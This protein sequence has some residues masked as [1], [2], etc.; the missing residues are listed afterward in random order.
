MNLEGP[1]NDNGSFLFSARR[2]YLDLIFEAAGFAFIPEYWDFHAK[3]NQRLNSSNTLSFL[4]IGAIGSVKLNNDNEENR[5]DNSRVAVPTQKQ[6]FSGLTWKHLFEKGFTTVTLGQTLTDYSTFQN[7]INLNKIL[8]N[9]SREAE[10]SLRTDVDIM[11]TSN[12]QLT[13]GNQLKWATKLKY[14]VFVAGFFRTD[15]NGI[16]QEL[17]I[18]TTFQTYKNST[19]VSY[20]QGIGQHKFTLGGRLEYINYVEEKWLFSPRISVLYQINPVS[21]ISVSGGRYFQSPSKIWLIGAPQNRQLKAIQADQ[22]VLAY[23]HTPLE[24]VKVQVEVYHKWYSNYPARLWRPYAVLAPTGFDDISNDIPFGLEPL[25]SQ[26]KGYSRGFEIFIQK[27]LSEIPLYGLLS[28]TLS[29]S[30]FKSLKGGYRP[31]TYDS[32]VIFNLAAGY[33]INQE[34]E[35]SSKFRIATGQPT[36]AFLPGGQR[37]WEN[38]NLGKRFPTFHA[39]DFRA[40]KRWNFTKYTLITYLDIQNIYGRKNVSNLR[41]NSKE[42]KIEYGRSIGVLPSIG[43]SFEF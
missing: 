2:S 41:W 3:F 40:D 42:N 31:S 27:K 8:Q 29:E 38:Y 7:D 1:T 26:G 32:R 24:D 36:T 17:S 43:V 9:D 14:D 39:L 15:E 21:A 23:D 10:T 19:Y 20:T 33:R 4:T 34:W 11:V 35:L 25:V 16:P 6:Y 30:K 18:D 37:D 5:F 12:G 28:F 13:F 22:V